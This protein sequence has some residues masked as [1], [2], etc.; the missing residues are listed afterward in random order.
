MR[1]NV[2]FLLSFSVSSPL[3]ALF[4]LHFYPPLFLHAPFNPHVLEVLAPEGFGEK[5]Q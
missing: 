4:F 3:V 5:S 1:V 2:G